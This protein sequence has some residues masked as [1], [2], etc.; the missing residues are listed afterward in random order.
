MTENSAHSKGLNIT[1]GAFVML[2]VFVGAGMLGLP[3]AFF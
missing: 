1:N 2:S 3:Y